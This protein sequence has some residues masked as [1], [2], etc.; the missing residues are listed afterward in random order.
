[1]GVWTGRKGRPWRRARAA[2]LAASTVCHLCRH[3]GAGEADH[4]PLPLA[5][6]ISRGMNPN[7][8]D[9]LRPAHG[10]S[11]PCPTCGL[12]CNQVKGN[13]INAPRASRSRAW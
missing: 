9:N 2:C 8:P 1:M 5:E 7:D 3:E 11:S 12:C 4:H 10:S 13:K 6:L